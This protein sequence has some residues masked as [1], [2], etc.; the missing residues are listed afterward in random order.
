MIDRSTVG[1]PV[2]AAF[3]DVHRRRRG[4]RDPVA[5]L[6]LPRG[7]LLE[8]N[9]RFRK[10]FGVPDPL[11]P[12]LTIL[13]LGAPELGSFL[14]GWDGTEPRLIR[15]MSVGGI[16]GKGRL[17]PIPATFPV[18]A[19]LQF[20]PDRSSADDAREKDAGHFERL[21]ALGETAAVIVHQIRIPLS[22]VQLGVESV[23]SSPALD[24]SLSPRLET[25]LEQ[26][27]RL[28]HLLA[29]IGNFARPRWPVPRS[30][31]VRKTL[32]DALAAV[33]AALRGPRTT[34][35][36]QV[37]PDPLWIVADPEWVAE[38]VQNLIVN[39]VEAKPEG[40]VIHLSAALSRTR[41][42]WVEIRVVDQGPGIPPFLL[43]RVFQ[44]F[45]TTKRTGTGLGL[46]IVK[47][48]VELHGGFVTLESEPGR[49]T[50]VQ[51]DLPSGSR[52]E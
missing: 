12:D 15:R 30:M 10:L 49:G 29:S 6:G 39:A 23:R 8:V 37:R 22:S 40:G 13:S 19:L 48:L 42:G 33:E 41:Q 21:R 31:E 9:S 50:T 18:Q 27:G 43:D 16:V 38:A 2:L 20:T 7:A 1:R 11:P 17:L 47:N 45:F 52:G 35:T 3:E 25:A 5:V 4:S 46:A 51:I 28:D 32:S 24:P 26:L 34:V 36:L 44:P 14:R